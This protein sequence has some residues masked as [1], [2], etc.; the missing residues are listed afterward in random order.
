MAA[1]ESSEARQG[2]YAR[3][4]QA[5]QAAMGGTDAQGKP[6]YPDVHQWL[7][8]QYQSPEA[9]AELVQELGALEAE[10][11]QVLGLQPGDFATTVPQPSE[12]VLESGET[13]QALKILKFRVWQF[14]FRRAGQV[15]SGASL[16]AV[17]DCLHKNLAGVGNE[18]HKYPVPS[19]VFF[20]DVADSSI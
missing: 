14:D 17:R 8:R 6:E 11:R 20:Q 10:C 9:Q 12:M 2:L 15:K 18:T 4:W 16:H 19:S 1:S 13:E 5:M 7:E 3:I